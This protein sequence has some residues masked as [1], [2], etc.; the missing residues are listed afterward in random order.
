MTL[1]Q[2]AAIAVPP[3][4]RPGFDHADV[5]RTAERS[6]MYVAHTGADRIDVF[7][8]ARRAYLRQLPEHP[9][10]AGVLIDSERD[11]LLA[12]D[13]GAARLSVYRVSDES[14]LFRVAVGHRPN[15]V[16]LDTHR[17]NAYTFDLGDP[18]GEACTFTVVDLERRVVIAQQ[19]LPG[20]P[21]W[22]TYDEASRVLYA[23]I[24]DPP[25][26]VVIDA[27]TAD[28]TRTIAVPAVG[29]HG[30]AIIDGLL[31]CAADGGELVVLET[32]GTVRARLPLSGSPDVLMYDRD[33][34]R[35]YVAIGSSGHV[36]SFDTNALRPVET[37]PTEEGAHTIGW[38]PDRKE[39]WAFA[40]RASAALVFTDST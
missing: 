37:V 36:Q 14:L 10:V 8:C 30:L 21:R 9:G 3:G 5:Y 19:P 6:R 11:L 24:S 27:V 38:D 25:C 23:N 28:I 7:D 31:F 40:P 2:V 4:P 22:A 34:G 29:P 20:R 1:R 32:A 15:G 17:M 13:R 35:A 26:V 12:T 16:A 18:P 33:L 39:L